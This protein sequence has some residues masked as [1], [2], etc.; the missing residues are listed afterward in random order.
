M[1]PQQPAALFIAIDHCGWTSNCTPTATWVGPNIA[2]V[3]VPE[4]VMYPPSAP[5][6][7]I[8][9]RYP[10]PKFASDW[11]RVSAISPPS[12]TTPNKM[13]RAVG[14]PVLSQSLNAS[15][16]SPGERPPYC[17]SATATPANAYS[18]GLATIS[19]HHWPSN[20]ELTTCPKIVP[21][22]KTAYGTIEPPGPGRSAPR[23]TMSNQPTVMIAAA[24]APA[25]G[26]PS[27]Q[28]ETNT[29][30]PSIRPEPAP[31]TR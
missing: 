22:T 12:I 1:V 16:A 7:G 3:P 30:T 10:L 11:A 31:M 21:S 25:T 13:Y 6:S 29:R 9:T 17:H 20:P 27:N 15:R 26:V 14:T 4:A 18:A 19:V 28:F 8:S 5:T 24:T 23:R 2:L